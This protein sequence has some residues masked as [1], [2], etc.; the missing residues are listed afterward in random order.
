MHGPDVTQQKH[1]WVADL[2]AQLVIRVDKLLAASHPGK[3]DG[4]I[5][6]GS[7]GSLDEVLC[8]ERGEREW[9][10]TDLPSSSAAKQIA[11]AP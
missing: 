10:G 3:G 8:G 1:V 9:V 2:H 6:G 11:V 4:G 5:D 7:G